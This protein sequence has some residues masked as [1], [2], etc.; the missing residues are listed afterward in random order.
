MVSSTAPLSSIDAWLY[1]SSNT[2]PTE[3]RVALI[4]SR[5]RSAAHRPASVTSSG[6]VVGG[7]QFGD[8]LALVARPRGPASPARRASRLSPSVRI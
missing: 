7:G 3:A 6:P 1:H 8:V 5:I 4:M 2:M